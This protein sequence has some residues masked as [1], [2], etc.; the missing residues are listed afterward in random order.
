MGGRTGRGWKTISCPLTS[1]TSS[2]KHRWSNASDSSVIV[3]RRFGSRPRKPRVSFFFH[4]RSPLGDL[5]AIAP[6]GW[7]AERRMS[8]LFGSLFGLFGTAQLHT[9][10]LVGMLVLVIF[11]PERIAGWRTFR[12]SVVLFVLAVALPGLVMLTPAAEKGGDFA[13]QLIL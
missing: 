6:L 13:D 11:R 10:L 8:A 1:T 9:V 12:V 2:S 7:N 5:L 4:N 3:P